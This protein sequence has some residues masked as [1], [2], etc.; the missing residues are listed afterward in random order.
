M[1]FIVL[2]WVYTITC[3]EDGQKTKTQQ[4][5]LE[6]FG[7]DASVRFLVN[8]K[9][10]ISHNSLPLLYNAHI[11]LAFEKSAPPTNSTIHYCDF[12]PVECYCLFRKRF[13]LIWL[14]FYLMVEF[15][16]LHHVTEFMTEAFTF[17]NIEI[18]LIIGFFALM[19]RNIK[20]WLWATIVSQIST[21]DV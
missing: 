5:A 12:S 10:K 4:S 14:F 16:W 3:L 11:C 15:I 18:R 9:M 8:G 19:S 6:M 13:V 7:S 17:L 1:R 21:C 2:Q 20:L